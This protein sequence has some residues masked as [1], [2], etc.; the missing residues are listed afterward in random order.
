MLEWTKED[1]FYYVTINNNLYGE[2]CVLRAWGS[3]RNKRGGKKIHYFAT[4]EEVELLLKKITSRR[5]YRG[6]QKSEDSYNQD[7]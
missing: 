6:Y 7:L 2:I 3:T 5:K 4:E 1:K